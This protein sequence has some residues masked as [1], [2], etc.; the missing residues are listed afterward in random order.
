MKKLCEDIAAQIAL[1][2]GGRIT[3]VQ[4]VSAIERLIGDD[5][6]YVT[7][8]SVLGRG[9]HEDDSGCDLREPTR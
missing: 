3:T 9:R 7:L 6:E 4:L 5:E 8:D 2:R 1:Y